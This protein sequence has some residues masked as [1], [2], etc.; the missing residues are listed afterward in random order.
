MVQPVCAQRRALRTQR[1]IATTQVRTDT[2]AE[3][4]FLKVMS[5]CPPFLRG[6][7]FSASSSSLLLHQL[8]AHHATRIG[9]R[10]DIEVEAGRVVENRLHRRGGVWCDRHCHASERAGAVGE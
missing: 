3:I 2:E 6:G 9:R 7:E 8:A 5:P 1:K 4:P 10:V